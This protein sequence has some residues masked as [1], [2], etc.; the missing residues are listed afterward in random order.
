MREKGFFIRLQAEDGQVLSHVLTIVL[1]AVFIGAIIIQCGPVIWN[2]IS[3]H[4]TADD[5]AQEAAI[6]YANS[7]GDMDRVYEAVNGV[8]ESSD[9]RLDGPINVLKGLNGEP[10]MVT[11]SIRK[12]ANTF[13]FEKVGYL[14]KYTEAHA[15][16]EY[17]IP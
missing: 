12:I 11:V 4:G 10:D 5:A 8:L 9:A 7:R 17:V 2:H 3:I 14:S 1:I 13:L 15:Y 6:T 16:S